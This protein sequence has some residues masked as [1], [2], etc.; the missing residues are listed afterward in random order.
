MPYMTK[1]TT[2]S[3][4]VVPLG[5]NLYGTCITSAAVTTKFVTMAD[6]NVLVAGVTIHVKFTNSNTAYA[7]S[8]TVG[9][10]P[11]ASIR[12]NGSLAGFW[13]AGDVVSF[14]YDGT[15]WVQNDVARYVIERVNINGISIGAQS[16]ITSR[17]SVAKTGYKP[18]GVVGFNMSNYGGIHVHYCFP[19]AIHV[20]DGTSN[21][22]Y[23]ITNTH[24]EES[25]SIQLSV[26]VLYEIA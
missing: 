12:C 11:A 10:A 15:Y 20:E 23:Q 26:W 13:S 2:Q 6:F 19:W 4:G 14:T 17:A 1:I 25:T 16:Y 8:L 5:S 24:E 9:S 3:E 7:P 21:V 22:Y 18:V